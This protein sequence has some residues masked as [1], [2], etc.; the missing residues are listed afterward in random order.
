[1]LHRYFSIDD[2]DIR[3]PQRAATH[4]AK[5]ARQF[6]PTTARLENWVR[7]NA[8]TAGGVFA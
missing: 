3:N 8:I 2:V 1:M 6:G 5:F 7:E 4:A